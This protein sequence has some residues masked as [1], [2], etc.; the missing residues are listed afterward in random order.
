MSFCQWNFKIKIS[1]TTFIENWHSH[2][3]TARVWN[4]IYIFRQT[5]NKIL[6]MCIFPPNIKYQ[7]AFHATKDLLMRHGSKRISTS[8]ILH[9]TGKCQLFFVLVFCVFMTSV[10]NK[11]LLDFLFVINPSRTLLIFLVLYS[12]PG[13]RAVFAWLYGEFFNLFPR[14]TW[15]AS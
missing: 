4:K 8:Q 1:I 6:L 15:V 9:K 14:V 5:Y 2:L 3:G 13:R 10:A 7:L 12:Y 11:K